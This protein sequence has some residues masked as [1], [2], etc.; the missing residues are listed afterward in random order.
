MAYVSLYRKYRPQTFEDVVGQDHITRTLKNAITEG[1]IASGYLFCGTRGTAKTTCARILAKALNCVGPDGTNDAPTPQPCGV[2]GPCRAIAA[3]SFVDVVEMDAASHRGIDD[4]RDITAS[5]KFPPMEGRYKVYIID[6]AHQLSNDAKDAFL[7]T[8]EEPPERVLFILATTDQDK[9]PITIQS[10]CQVFEFKRGSVAQIAARLTEV[11][12]A[13]GVTADPS[14]VTLVARAAD[15]SYRDSLSLLEQVLAYRRDH[16][17]AQDVSVVLGTVDEEVLARVV[18]LVADSDAAGAFALAGSIL[19]SGKDVRQFLKSLAGR[20]R[21]M[22]FVGVGARPQ[23]AGEMD[24][25]PDLRAQASR[26]APASLL[27]ALEVLTEAEREMRTNTQHRLL[28]EMALLRL[29]RLPASPEQIAPRPPV[30]AK[31]EQATPAPAPPALGAGGAALPPPLSAEEED[32]LDVPLPGDADLDVLDYED[33]DVPVSQIVTSAEEHEQA[34]DLL[35]VQQ[36]A[37]PPPAPAAN[38]HA[39]PRPASDDGSAPEELTRLQKS[40]QEVINRVGSN[41]PA[42]SA[43]IKDGRAVALHGQ[44][45]T[46]EFSSS[47][48]VDRITKNE[49][50]RRM[51]EDQINRTLGEP[52]GTY[53]IKGVLRGDGGAPGKVAQG[54]SPRPRG[55]EPTVARPAPLDPLMD[56]VIAVF[57][58]RIEED[59]AKG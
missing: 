3:S 22:L 13:E 38:G 39:A 9:M 45:F 51:I 17:T 28:L 4:M 55:P 42:A 37:A 32:T 18:G 57:G 29:M 2:C 30:L 52:E 23:A 40:W 53:K 10:R 14:A 19:E 15:G 54:V 27:T 7:K 8:L 48:N 46:L 24:D 43:L 58:G 11:L 5:I 16:L 47:F 35:Q 41:K 31:E 34:E 26:F 59:D 12:R 6:E 49:A 33:D 44:T 50:G 25:S 56:E 1:R 20:F 36:V 21:D